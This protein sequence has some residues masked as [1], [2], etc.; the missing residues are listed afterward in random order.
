MKKILYLLSVVVLPTLSFSQ[1]IQM[2]PLYGIYGYIQGSH[3]N[4]GANISGYSDTLRC[5]DTIITDVQYS[6]S[7]PF[8]GQCLIIM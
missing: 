3:S 7:F 8:L 2:P 6:V 5:K 1:E 4:C